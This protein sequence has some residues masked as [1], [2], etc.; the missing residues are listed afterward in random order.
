VNIKWSDAEKNFVRTNAHTMKDGDIASQLSESS[1]RTIT[2]QSVRKMRQKLGIKKLA[3]RGI[4]GVVSPC[5][6]TVDIG[7]SNSD[8]CIHQLANT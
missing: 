5:T 2:L 4:C 8:S 3:G 6:S 1:G 7:D